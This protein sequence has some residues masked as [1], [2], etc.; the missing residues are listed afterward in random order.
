MSNHCKYCSTKQKN[1]RWGLQRYIIKFIN[2]QWIEMFF[3]TFLK[4]SD[5]HVKSLSFG[6]F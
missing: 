2:E 4:V 1:N 5:K 3:E 6:L